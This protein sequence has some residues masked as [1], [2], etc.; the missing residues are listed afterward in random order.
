MRDGAVVAQQAHNLKVAGSN[1][2]PATKHLTKGQGETML[3]AGD[4]VYSEYLQKR[5]RVA[6]DERHGDVWLEDMHVMRAA[7]LRL[8][9]RASRWRRAQTLRRVSETF[10]GEVAILA[11]EDLDRD[12]R[13]SQELALSIIDVMPFVGLCVTAALLCSIAIYLLAQGAK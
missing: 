11:R 1:P 9:S 4:L 5:V 3:R 10:A 13:S 8:I 7:R 2:A 12:E 6:C